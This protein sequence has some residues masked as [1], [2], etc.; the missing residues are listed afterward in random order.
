MLE[1]GL[2]FL[3][4]YGVFLAK[5]I[6]IVVAILAV[7]VMVLGLTVKHKTDKGELKITNLTDEYKELKHQLHQE[8]LSKK[9]LKAYEKEFKAKQ[10]AEEKASKN[11]TEDDKTKRVFVVEFKGGIDAKEVANLREEI[12]AILTIADKT[13]DEVLVKVE[14]GGGMVH[15]YGLGASQLD[16]LRQ[17]E[18]P[19]TVCVDK[20]AAS[21]GYMMACVAN[22]IYAAPFAILGS[23]GVIAQIPNFN[24]LLKKHDI[25]Y[26][27]HTAGDYKRTLTMFGENTDKGR[28]KF[29]EELEQTHVLF[30]SFVGNYRPELDL[31]KV[32]NGEHWYGQQAINLGLVDD[33]ATSDDVILSHVEDK[34]VV[35]VSY[36][37]KKKLADKLGQG[38]SVA[39][40]SIINRLAEKNRFIG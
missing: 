23:I 6:T 3:Y 1:L 11:S 27:Q 5:A 13:Q 17:A 7:L 18:I 31:D 34:Q 22:K 39:V 33:I 28:E 14:S 25:D 21:G 16:R 32:A 37:Q 19:L 40:D 10:K 12:S 15:A 20:V 35:K 4:E 26:E 8:L 2:E 29:C 9:Q 38:A 36:R 24:K 30:K